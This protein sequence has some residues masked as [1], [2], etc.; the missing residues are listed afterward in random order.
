MEDL[1]DHTLGRSFQ[2]GI[3]GEKL[4]VMEDTALARATN[5][6]PGTRQIR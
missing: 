6:R 4:L 3:H 5:H 1:V 2:F